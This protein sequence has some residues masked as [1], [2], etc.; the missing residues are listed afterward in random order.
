M[1]KGV[2]LEIVRSAYIKEPKGGGCVCVWGFP[3]ARGKVDELPVYYMYWIHVQYICWLGVSCFK[4]KVR[5][6]V[7]VLLFVKLVNYLGTWLLL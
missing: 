6:L 4:L 3:V 1:K 7:S 5:S 2:F